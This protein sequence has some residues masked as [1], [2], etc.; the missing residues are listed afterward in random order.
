MLSSSPCRE[1]QKERTSSEVITRHHYVIKQESNN[2]IGSH[3][4]III[5]KKITAFPCAVTEYMS[6]PF[7]ASSTAMLFLF[8][9]HARYNGYIEKVGRHNN[10]K[11]TKNSY[12]SSLGIQDI[13]SYTS[14]RDETSDNIF[15]CVCNGVMQGSTSLVCGYNFRKKKDIY[16]QRVVVLPSRCLTIASAPPRAT[17]F[18]TSDKSP[19]EKSAEK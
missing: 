6:A 7:S 10:T 18:S 2:S 12:R 5:L 1:I 3:R 14:S 17:N 19:Y 16:S 9:A 11:E 8:L 15:F 4:E 13:N